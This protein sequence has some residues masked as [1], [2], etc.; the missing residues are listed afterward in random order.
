MK[1]RIISAVF[2]PRREARFSAHK[3]FFYNHGEPTSPLLI[4]KKIFPHVAKLGS[5]HTDIGFPFFPCR[6]ACFSTHK[7]LFSHAEKPGSRHPN[8]IFPTRRS[9]VFGTQLSGFLFSHAEKPA[10]RH[11]KYFFCTPRSPVPGTQKSFF[12]RQE[13]GKAR[14]AFTSPRFIPTF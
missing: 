1:A 14:R 11:T 9:P 7:K 6:E 4:V 2:S 8:I 12:P 10:S 5:L 13:A 3:T